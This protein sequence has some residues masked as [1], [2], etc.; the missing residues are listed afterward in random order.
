MWSVYVMVTN[1]NKRF[2]KAQNCWN[3]TDFTCSVGYYG[4]L[5]WTDVLTK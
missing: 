4:I 3:V 5:N 2:V 1:K